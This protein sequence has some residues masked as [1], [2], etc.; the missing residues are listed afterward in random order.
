MTGFLDTPIGRLAIDTED[1]YITSIRITD[2]RPTVSHNDPLISMAKAWLDDYFRG[3][4]PSPA[5]LPLRPKGTPFQR[6]V[7][8]LLLK[9]PFGESLSYG[10]LAQEA[11]R[12]LGKDRMSAQA[13]GGAVGRN[14]ILIAI[15]CHRVLGSD[16]SLTG[17]S[18]GI[19]K[20]IILLEHEG[21]RYQK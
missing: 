8:S 4:A 3:N 21:I 20:K 16:G 10:A 14:P 17:F 13:I 18:D 2:E 6:L 7:W 19:D 1:G 5:T 12:L 9:I 11:A 15:P